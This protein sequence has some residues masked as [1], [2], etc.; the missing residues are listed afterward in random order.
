[1]TEMQDGYPF[2]YHCSLL[3]TFLCKRLHVKSLLDVNQC[4]TSC[5]EY[6]NFATSI[7]IRSKHYTRFTVK[8]DLI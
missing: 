5:T 6:R 7:I 4:N 3:T 8:T 2:I 1:M